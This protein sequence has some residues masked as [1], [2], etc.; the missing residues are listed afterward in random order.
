MMH[1]FD[2]IFYRIYKFSK[3]KGDNAPETNG[4]LLLSLMQ[5][6]SVIDIMIAVKIVHEYSFPPKFYFLI[7]LVLIAFLNWVRYER[8]FGIDKFD[9]RWG[10]EDS[11]RRMRNG[12][13]IGLYLVI[14]FLIP[15]V[16]GY[17][18]V[19]LKLI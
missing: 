17:L 13:F 6:L 1:F 16:Y 10:N 2:Y 19:N 18:H 12:W 4:S 15:V 5:F 11:F 8:N 9:E 7:P 14:S 3:A